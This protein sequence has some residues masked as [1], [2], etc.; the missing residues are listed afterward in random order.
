MKLWQS[1]HPGPGAEAGDGEGGEGEGAGGALQPEHEPDA[2]GPPG[3]DPGGHLEREP[4]EAD[5]Q[6]PARAHHRL[7]A[8]QGILVRL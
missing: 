4:P 3:P 6:R 8:V 1:I 5:Q 7:D 2:G